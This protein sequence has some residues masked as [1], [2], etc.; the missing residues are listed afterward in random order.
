MLA[1]GVGSPLDPVNS[2]EPTCC[3]DLVRLSADP[4]RLLAQ[5]LHQIASTPAHPV[6]GAE[7]IAN[8]VGVPRVVLR[9][10]GV[11]DWWCWCGTANGSVLLPP[12]LDALPLPDRALRELGDRLREVWLFREVVHSLA[13]HTDH[14]RNLLRPD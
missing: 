12:V 9:T 13:G 8:G 2:S 6:G 1:A 11:A 7:K 3:L 4:A 14:L 10:L 5:A